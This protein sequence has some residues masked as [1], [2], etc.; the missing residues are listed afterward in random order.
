MGSQMRIHKAETAALVPAEMKTIK[1]VIIIRELNSYI[2]EIPTAPLLPAT[3]A[4]PM[5]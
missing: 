3:F 5:K 2:N 1:Q 4:I